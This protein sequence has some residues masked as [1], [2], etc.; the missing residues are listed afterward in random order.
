MTTT[1]ELVLRPYQSEDIAAIHAAEA[2]GVRAQLGVAATGLGKTVV[3]VSLARERGGRT[4]ILVHRDELVRQAAHKIT[5][6]WPDARLGIIKGDANDIHGHAIVASVQTL[7]RQRRLDMLMATTAHKPFDL[8][9]VD[10]A[11]HVAA[12]SY[13]RVLDALDAGRPGGPLLLGVTATPDRGDGAG[14]D[15][16]F[17]EIVFNRDI[18]WGIRAGYLSDLRGKR[19]EVSNLNLAGLKVRSGDFA[20]EEA[21]QRMMDAEAPTFIAKAWLEH[22]KGRRTLVF[23]PT[24]EVARETAAELGARGVRA[25]YVSGDMPL[26]ERRSVLR[27]YSSGELEVVANCAVLTEGFDEPRTDCV[28]MARPTKSRA[29][30]TQCVGRG[31]RR[32]PDKVDCLVLDVC[33][34]SDH[35][36]LITVPSLFGV[37]EPTFK[38]KLQDGTEVATEV[39]DKRDRQLVKIGKLKASDVDLFRKMRGEGIAWVQAHEPG[40][41]LKRYVRSLGG[42]GDDGRPLPTVVLAQRTPGEDDWNVGLWH[43]DGTKEL[44]WAHT[45]LEGAQACGEDYVRSHGRS[46]IVRSNSGFRRRRPTEGQLAAAA[47]WGLQVNPRWNAGQLSDA[48]DAHIDRRKRQAA[49]RRPR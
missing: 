48:L 9:V 35:H 45:T 18:L 13:G 10:E 2:R 30:Y 11:H 44:L 29:L 42:R 47:R 39:L 5:E 26:D 20:Q 4:L 33:G 19:I 7:S 49:T 15:K 41:I 25:A 46:T 21:G 38:R 24:V 22:A 16:H 1:H 34:V 6:I 3:F 28:V 40:A 32:H 27:R 14:L 12:D 8:I 31:T 17:S 43:S 37:D 36:S 23:T